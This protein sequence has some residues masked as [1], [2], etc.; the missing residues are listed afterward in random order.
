MKARLRILREHARAFE[1]ALAA[2]ETVEA[3]EELRQRSCA[4]LAE[5]CGSELVQNLLSA[6]AR[7]LI[8]E[9][10][11]PVAAGSSA[12]TDGGRR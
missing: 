11:Q 3:G 4:R 6:R 7:R 9:K 10:F 5:I 12:P 1:V 2:A 8:Q